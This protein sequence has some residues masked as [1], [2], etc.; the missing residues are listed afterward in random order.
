M[1]G[2]RNVPNEKGQQVVTVSFRSIP[3]EIELVF[4]DPMEARAVYEKLRKELNLP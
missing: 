1:V 4:D 3:D 2:I